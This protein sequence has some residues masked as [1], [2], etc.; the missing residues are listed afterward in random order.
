MPAAA[1]ESTRGKTPTLAPPWQPGQSGN[2][3][4]RPKGSKNKLGEDFVAALCKDF[5]ENGE[6]TIKIARRT[7]PVQYLKVIAAVIPKEVIH[8]VEDYADISDDELEQ[9]LIAA[10]RRI[11]DLRTAGEASGTPLLPSPVSN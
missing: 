5:E 3:L 1:G 10:A 8:K 2:P 11:A 4:G 6:D 7:D 9:R